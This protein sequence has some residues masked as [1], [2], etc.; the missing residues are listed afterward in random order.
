M[1]Q[2]LAPGY[3]A[4]RQYLC[5]SATPDRQRSGAE[6]DLHWAH[7]H[8]WNNT[9]LGHTPEVSTFMSSPYR[10]FLA[11]RSAEVCTPLPIA[12]AGQSILLAGDTV[13]TIYSH[14][15]IHI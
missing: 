13:L 3:S 12:G 15:S 1:R 11:C 9:S 4:R 2:G 5:S 14:T 8:P 7:I 6:Q 10:F